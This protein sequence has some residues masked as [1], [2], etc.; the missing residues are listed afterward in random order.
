MIVFTDM[1]TNVYFLNL[2]KPF[3]SFGAYYNFSIRFLWENMI[4][5]RRVKE[6]IVKV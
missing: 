5:L 4:A 3:S 6:E 1:Q 2:T